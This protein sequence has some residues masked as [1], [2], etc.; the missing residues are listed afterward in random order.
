LSFKESLTTIFFALNLKLNSFALAL[1]LQVKSLLTSL[2]YSTPPDLLAGGQGLA[3]P[4]QE[5]HTHF[6]HLGLRLGALR[7]S[8]FEPFGPC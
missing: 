3:S 5:P 4:P 6:G 2:P 8:S 7:A 1:A